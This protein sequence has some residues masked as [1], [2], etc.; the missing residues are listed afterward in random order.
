MDCP[1][2]LFG[3]LDPPVYLHV[4]GRSAGS[5]SSAACHNTHTHTLSLS[6]FANENSLLPVQEKWSFGPA[7]FWANALFDYLIRRPARIPGF[8]CG[9]KTPSLAT[10]GRCVMKEKTAEAIVLARIN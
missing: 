1:R 2:G 6:P 10:A 7:L 3:C 9:D 8:I 5:L 4:C